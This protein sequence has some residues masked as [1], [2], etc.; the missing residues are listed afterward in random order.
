MST[1][2]NPYTG[3]PD[4]VGTSTGVAGAGSYPAFILMDSLS[5]RW[6][7]TVDTTGHLVTTPMAS[8]PSGALFAHQIVLKDSSGI[9]WT[10]TINTIG[11]LITTV[12]G[13]YN[14]SVDRIPIV[15]VNGVTW[16]LTVLTSGNLDTN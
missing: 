2:F 12:G 4:F 10:V 9:F 13:N 15:D 11:D 5:V 8:G 3:L 14:Q 1:R 6:A 7:V 16:I